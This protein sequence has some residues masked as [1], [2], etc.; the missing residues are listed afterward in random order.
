MNNIKGKGKKEKTRKEQKTQ[1]DTKRYKSLDQT[2]CTE[3]IFDS[4][5]FMYNKILLENLIE[6]VSS[7][8]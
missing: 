3:L 8:L 4:R 2:V 1:I 6:A 5:P 7:H